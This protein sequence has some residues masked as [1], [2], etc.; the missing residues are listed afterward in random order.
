METGV[1]QPRPP[2]HQRA[3]DQCLP[4]PAVPVPG[5]HVPVPV[6]PAAGVPRRPHRTHFDPHRQGHPEPRQLCQVSQ[7]VGRAGP[8]RGGDGTSGCVGRATAPAQSP[9]LAT[10]FLAGKD[11]FASCW[12][13]PHIS[14]GLVPSLSGQGDHLSFQNRTSFMSRKT[15]CFDHMDEQ[16]GGGG[17]FV[18]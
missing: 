10:P 18:L 11:L 12:L 14:L 5:H 7:A 4:V 13:F 6:Q 9:T 1:Q 16:Q 17:D 2:G 8:G 3:P 15:G